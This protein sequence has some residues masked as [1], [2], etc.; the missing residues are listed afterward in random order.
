MPQ[1][2]FDESCDPSS[3]PTLPRFH[4]T[5]RSA[6]PNAWAQWKNVLN[7]RVQSDPRTAIRQADRN[8]GYSLRPWIVGGKRDPSMS[9]FQLGLHPCQS[10]V[11]VMAVLP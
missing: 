4:E 11:L 9:H 1:L 2:C 5:A 10:E 7:A 6:I 3:W 8:A